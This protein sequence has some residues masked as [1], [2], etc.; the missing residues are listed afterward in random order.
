MGKHKRSREELEQELREQSEA[1]RASATAY[2]SG[3]LWEAKRLA[4]TA[5]T[6]LHDGGK[7]SKSLLGQLG[8][9]GPMLS[10]AD[11]G[12]NAPMPLAT[13]TIG[14]QKGGPGMTFVPVLSEHKASQTLSFNKW[15]EEPVFVS[16][17][18]SLSRK[19]LIF[20]F[21]SQV[22]GAHVDGSINDDAFHWLDTKGP[23][24]V[25]T[26]PPG[27][28]H[29]IHGNEVECPPALQD[30]F[31]DYDGYVPNGHSATM[32]QIAWELDYKLKSVGY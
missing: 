1:L 18:L 25:K 29:D 11:H 19:N 26:G 24:H 20:T 7:N 15:Y 2:D 31:A 28:A 21:R 10:T 14:L 23:I 16:G 6:L 12:P 3:K 27:P 30:I 13:F 8:L 5:Y 17:A 22:G 4:T 9:K 32:R